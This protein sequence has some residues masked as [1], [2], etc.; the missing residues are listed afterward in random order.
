M[1]YLNDLKQIGKNEH[2]YIYGAGSFGQIF[3]DQTKRHRS[4]V[5]VLNFIDKHKKGFFNG[6]KII[7]PSEVKSET[8][9]IV[10]CVASRFWNSIYSDFK[11]QN[12]MFN[13]YHDFNVYDR[14][15][16]LNITGQRFGDEFISLFQIANDGKL[17][18]YIDC[19][20]ERNV[21]AIGE[22]NIID[23]WCKFYDRIMIGPG[24]VVLNGGGAFGNEN[25]KYISLSGNTGKVYSFDPN[26][27]GKIFSNQIEIHP[28]ILSGKTGKMSF[29][30]DGPR[31][32]IVSRGENLEDSIAIDD[33]V[34]KYRVERVDLI[35]LDVEGAELDVLLGAQKTIRKFHPKLAISV[36]H[37]VADFHEIPFFIA[38]LVSKYKFDLG[39]YN[40]QGV[41]TYLHAHV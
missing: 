9:K 18:I 36:Y 8:R 6:L 24:D 17:K 28:F 11:N 40:A 34:S 41:D 39:V 25:E 23:D 5:K 7:H 30:Y 27:R 21:K 29:L 14:D 12:L 4:D 31:S 1:R 19:I 16:K 33:F 26:H 20:E 13:N 3:F 15:C 35:K 32:R 37:S 10:V 22:Q 2:L 38:G